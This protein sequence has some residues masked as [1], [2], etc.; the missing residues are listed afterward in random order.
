[1]GT[2]TALTLFRGLTRQPRETTWQ[3]L[4][5]ATQAAALLVLGLLLA[6]SPLKA[7]L[8]LVIGGAVVLLIVR[9]PV[10]GLCLLSLTLPLSQ[11]WQ[12]SVA[13]AQVGL[14]ELLLL[15]TVAAWLVG[16][17]SRRQISIPHPPLAL[18]FLIFIGVQMLSLLAGQS[19]REG[20]PEL[21]KWLEMLTIYLFMSSQVQRRQVPWVVLSILV[22]AGLQAILGAYQFLLRVGPEPFVLMGRFMRAYGT[23]RQPNPYGGYLGLVLPVALSLAL[24]ALGRTFKGMRRPSLRPP[25][26]IFS[27]C[28]T[29][30]LFGTATLLILGLTLLLFGTATLLIL[31]GIGMSWSRGAWLGLVA[32]TAVVIGWR[33]RG[34]S[35]VVLVIVM[36]AASLFALGGLDLLPTALVDRMAGFGEYIYYATHP[37]VAT[38]EIT[39]ANFAVLERVAHWEA[40]WRMFRDRPWLGVGIGQYALSYPAYALARWSNPLGHAHNIYLHYLAETG[41]LGL[42]AYLLWLLSAAVQAWRAR[43]REDAF[44]RA[45]ALGAL[46]LIA[47]L[48]VH[49]LVDNL[50]VQGI[51]LQV[52]IVL[53]LL[54]RRLSPEG[55]SP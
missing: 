20:A 38:V 4:G 21:L 36:L 12:V 24:W 42:G 29:L 52:A 9:R 14:S 7:A 10:I 46:G 44:T 33:S 34:A 37:D 53:G 3:W 40:A 30:L 51:Y 1:M 28:L 8:A 27:R 15:L 45:L 2:V 17:A 18:P 39:D 26:G 43:S 16:M 54:P 35:I 13:G 47:H 55:Q 25:A 41:L 31:A 32:S 22:A 6:L 48:V 49:N 19:L 23:F 50:Y 5:K 11:I